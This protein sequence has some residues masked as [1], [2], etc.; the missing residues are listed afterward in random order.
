MKQSSNKAI[1]KL[2]LFGSGETSPAG[3]KIHRKVFQSLPSK[4]T[5]A[6]LETPAGFQPNSHLVAQDIADMFQK[7]FTEFVADVS[8]IPARKKGTKFSPDNK[9]LLNPLQKASYIFLGPGSPTYAL[10]QL[11]GSKALVDIVAA[12][13]RGATLVLSSAAAIAFGQQTLPVYEIY[14][15]GEDLHWKEGL[16]VLA[17]VGLPFTVVTHWNN[18]EGGKDLDT[19]FCYMGEDRFNKLLQLLPKESSVLGIDEH[20]AIIFDFAKDIFSIEGVGSVTLLKDKKQ[21]IFPEGSYALQSL[22]TFSV[23][24]IAFEKSTFQKPKETK[25]RDAIPATTLSKELQELLAER[26]KARKWGDFE[27]SDRIRKI[28]LKK[29]YN[30]EDTED[31]QEMYRE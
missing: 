4:Q 8:I 21:C 10:H 28:F 26:E 25:K 29:G 14:K 12:W 5:I 31:G 2:V 15:A 22:S 24:P 6:I 19:R 1:G 20:T 13:K 27:E 30:I 7:S 18:T 17:E 16:S 23:I 9:Q 3:R 11:N